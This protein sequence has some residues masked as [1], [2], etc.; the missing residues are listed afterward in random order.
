MFALDGVSCTA[1]H[2]IQPDNLGE[3]SSFDGNFVIRSNIDTDPQIF[4]PFEVVTGL[5]RIMQSATGFTPETGAHLQQSELCATCHTLFTTSLDAEGRE[6]SR[7]PE[8]TPYLEWKHSAFSES[9]SCQSCHMPEGCAGSHL[10]G[11]R[12]ASGGFLP[13]GLS[14]RQRIHAAPAGQVS[15]RAECESAVERSSARR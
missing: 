14:W 2:Q 1:C 8:Q 11:A 4:G 9:E 6:V 7:F 5:S 3:E 12:G 13:A 10:L 15:R